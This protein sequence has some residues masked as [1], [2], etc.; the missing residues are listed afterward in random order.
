M[1]EGSEQPRLAEI[2]GFHWLDFSLD[3][4][5]FDQFTIS[6]GAR[7]LFGNTVLN[8]TSMATG[9][10]HSAGPVRPVAFGRSYF[11]RLSFAV[12]KARKK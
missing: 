6:A 5:L 12:S 11:V 10:A 3:K 2:E 9:G 4:K 7:N 8:T 1:V